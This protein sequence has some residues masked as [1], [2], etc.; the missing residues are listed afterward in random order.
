MF[1][2]EMRASHL[3]QYSFFTCLY[4]GTLVLS[5]FILKPFLPVLFLSIIFAVVF[6]PLYLRLVRLFDGRRGAAAACVVLVVFVLIVVPLT[7]FVYML[8]D[9]AAGIYDHLAG[10]GGRE[11]VAR[12]EAL[13]NGL[14]AYAPGVSF[15]MGEYADLNTYL[16]LGLSWVVS[17]ASAFFSSVVATVLY[18]LL[19]F[20]ALFYFLKEGRSITR[21]LMLL[22][23]LKNS[24][25]EMIL[26]K[27]ATSIN[28]VVRGR[29][30]M[31]I[32]Q[33][34]FAGAGFA[35]FGVPNP[36]F[37]GFLTA[38]ASLVPMVGTSLVLVPAI[39]YLFLAGHMVAA[40]G[41]LAWG[42]IAVGFIDDILGPMLLE[43]GMKIHPFLVLL[44]VLGGLRLFGPIGF[45]AGPVVL[46]VLFVLTNIYILLTRHVEEGA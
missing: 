10:G 11:I 34:S 23:P 1:N 13:A 35:V 37:F 44:S 33:G 45:I 41:L 26:G 9:E 39:L 31:A 29:L 30:A 18:V 2:G 6:N 32:V 8:F 43:R 22:S 7:A 5:F 19:M 15:D 14:R 12:F 42:A 20:I 24:H 17:N 28:A 21:T 46:A 38:F 27:I 36:V 25:D 3:L 16:E 40:L 4:V